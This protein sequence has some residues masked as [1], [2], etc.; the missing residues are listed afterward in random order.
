M[1]SGVYLEATLH[2]VLVGPQRR[3]LMISKKCKHC[4]K[5]IEFVASDIEFY[6]HSDTQL[7]SCADRKPG[8]LREFAEPED[9]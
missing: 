4:H 2:I 9:N 1:A 3:E 5:D 8:S 6:M 7:L